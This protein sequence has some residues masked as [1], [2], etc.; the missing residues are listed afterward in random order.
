LVWVNNL[1]EVSLP[2][3]LLGVQLGRSLVLLIL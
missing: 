3:D 1:R 2:S